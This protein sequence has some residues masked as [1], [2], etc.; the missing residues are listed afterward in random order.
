MRKC[1][2]AVRVK[3][4]HYTNT[5]A[6]ARMHAHTGTHTHTRANTTIF[7]LH[8]ASLSFTRT[9]KHLITDNDCLAVLLALHASGT[10]SEDRFLR[11]T[12]CKKFKMFHHC[13]HLALSFQCDTHTQSS[14]FPTSL[15]SL[16]LSLSLSVF[17]SLS[18]SLTHSLSLSL[19]HSHSL[20]HTHMM[21][22]A[23]CL[24]LLT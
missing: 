4:Y 20:S 8:S 11:E 22:V 12:N 7:S 10:F 16:F 15:H 14:P 9:R 23:L 13:V 3:F 19:T 18:L 6:V 1:T 17:L 21:L 5:Y 24:L 2:F